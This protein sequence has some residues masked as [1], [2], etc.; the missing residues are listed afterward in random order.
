MPLT[1][2]TGRSGPP[3]SFRFA[4]PTRLFRRQIERRQRKADRIEAGIR[5]LPRAT[6]EQIGVGANRS[7]DAVVVVPQRVR[8]TDVTAPTN[9]MVGVPARTLGAQGRTGQGG[10]FGSQGMRTWRV[11]A[12]T[13][14]RRDH[15]SSE[16]RTRKRRASR[17]DRSLR[18]V[19]AHH[20]HLRINIRSESEPRGARKGRTPSSKKGTPA[21]SVGFAH[22]TEMPV[23][24]GRSIGPAARI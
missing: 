18:T 9:P 21:S 4:M 12:L 17:R 3:K 10:H 1:I 13:Y 19:S 6:R 7:D 23:K 16:S 20:R 5:I 24:L 14:F 8:F 2:Q 22:R 15:A 11:T